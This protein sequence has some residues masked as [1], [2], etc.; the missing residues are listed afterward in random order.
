MAQDFMSTFHVGSSD[1]TI[2][3]V[4]G[5]G[6]SARVLSAAPRHSNAALDRGTKR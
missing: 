3:Q 4:D 2:L 6:V 5:D 1:K